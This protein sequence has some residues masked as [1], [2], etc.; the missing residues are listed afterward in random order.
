MENMVDPM[1][2]LHALL[3]VLSTTKGIKDEAEQ[4]EQELEEQENSVG[5]I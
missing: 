3:E 5:V 4:L 1:V 2:I